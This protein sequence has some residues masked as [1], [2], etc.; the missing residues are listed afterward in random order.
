MGNLDIP[1]TENFKRQLESSRKG[2][3]LFVGA[4]LGEFLS[5]DP[6]G[7]GEKGLGDGHHS[8]WRR[9]WGS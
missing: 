9:R 1:L 6:E 4:L 3:P 2:A 8:P 5:G 7:H